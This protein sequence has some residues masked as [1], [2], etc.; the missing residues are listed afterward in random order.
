MLKH[1]PFHERTSALCVSQAWRRWAGHVVASS[2]DLSHDREYHAIRSSAALLDVS[3][4]YKYLIEG[5]DAT[6]LL[7]RVVTRDVARMQSRQVVYTGWCDSAG[8]VIDDGTISRLEEQRYRMTSAEPSLRWLSENAVGMNVTVVD[9]SD[10]TAALALQGPSSRVI[11]EQLTQT[12]LSAIKYFRLANTTARGIAI[13]I[14]RTG[15]T[16]DLG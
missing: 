7:D 3:P 1:T 12:D 6:R 10:S 14:S 2:Y 8:K 13:T 5:P 4:L 16:G 9:V 15:Y 11:L